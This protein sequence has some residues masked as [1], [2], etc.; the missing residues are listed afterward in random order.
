MHR[1]RPDDH[2]MV[3]M[4]SDATPMH[5]GSLQY[6]E[7]PPEQRAGFYDTV[8]AALVE[9]IAHSP[10]LQEL[11]PAPL[12]FDSD[13]WVGVASFDA[14]YHIQRVRETSPM[15]EEAVH[16]EVERCCQERLDLA[17]PPFRVRVLDQLADGRCAIIM[18]VHHGF[19]DGVGFQSLLAQLYDGGAPAD[20]PPPENERLPPPALWL[21]ASAQRFQ[22]ER[23][24]RVQSALNRRQA[25]AAIK[26]LQADPATRRAV[27][28]TLGLSGATSEQRAYATFSLPL[29]AIKAIGR[30]LDGT[31]NDVFLTL[32]GTALRSY[33]LEIGDLPAEPLVANS[34][35]SYRRP[36]HG[37]IGN[38]IV[39]IHPHLGTHLAD[40]LQRFRAVQAS[41]ANERQRTVYDEALLNQPEVPFGA[42]DRREKIGQRVSSGGSVL[43]GN[44]S[45]SNV[46]GPAEPRFL[47]GFRL[48]ANYPTPLLGNSRWMNVTLRRYGDALD[49]G[50]MVDPTKVTR[51][52]RFVELLQAALREY[53]VLAE[54]D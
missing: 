26:R 4:E 30:R 23:A 32:I 43:P 1:L 11:R 5:I 35:R 38:R 8:R 20:A 12:G 14:G 2:F 51:I 29:P 13:V 48:L 44:V 40:P 52:E 53:S 17:R 34:A 50:I 54:T 10:L 15:N 36:E 46:P 16:R 22:R 47:A 28:P 18:H 9:R 24:L 37:L 7:V 27:T 3:L 6:F 31:V 33:L 41:M 45:L 21:Q 25:L 39:A 42:R 19:A 49:F